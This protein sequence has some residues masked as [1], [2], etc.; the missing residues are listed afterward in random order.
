VR[1]LDP[2][3]HLHIFTNGSLATAFEISGF[4]PVAAWYFGM[5]VYELFTQLTMLAKEEV[6]RIDGEVISALQSAIDRGQLSD[7]MVVAGRPLLSGELG[8]E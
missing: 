6:A 1:H 2:I 7:S 3:G 5:D 8:K 4:A